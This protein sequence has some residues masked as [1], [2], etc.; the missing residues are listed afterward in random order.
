M[1]MK[2]KRSAFASKLGG[3]KKPHDPAAI[4]SDAGMVMILGHHDAA[5]APGEPPT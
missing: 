2:A 1:L 3:P 5:A 4:R